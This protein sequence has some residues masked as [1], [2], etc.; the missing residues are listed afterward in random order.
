[1]SSCAERLPV[2]V[3][4]NFQAAYGKNK[5][6]LDFNQVKFESFE[7]LNL[8]FYNGDIWIK[9][10]ITNGDGIGSYMVINNDLICRNYRFYKWNTLTSTLDAAEPLRDLD[11]RDDRTHNFPNPNFKI[12]LKPF[13]KATYVIKLWSDGR[14]IDASPRLMNMDQYTQ[15]INQKTVWSYAFL[16]SM[17][18]L[19]FINFYQWRVL[20]RDIYLYY[21]LYMFSTFL[22][23][24]GL[25]GFW[26]NFGLKHLY[27]DHIIFVA[28]R[29]W[30]FSLLIYTSKFLD[31]K[32][33]APRYFKLLKWLL[34][35]VLGGSTLYQFIFFN[36]SIGSLHMYENSMSFVWLCLIVITLLFSI[37][38]KK[39]ELKYYLIPLSCFLFFTILG[40][41]DGYIKTLPG[42][43]FQYIKTGTL[44]EFIGFTYLIALLIKTKLK[45]SEL[46]RSEFNENKKELMSVSEKLEAL[47]QEKSTET[48]MNKADLVGV[49]KLLENSIVDDTSWEEFKLRFESLNPHFHSNIKALH[50][51]LSKSEMRLL[52]LIKID[53]SQKEIANILN[54]EP[55]SVK[56][57]KSRVRKKLNISSSTVLKDYISKF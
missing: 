11:R 34:I 41:I 45:N 52:T 1:M 47:Q 8:G 39:L 43:P 54:I 49:L 26:Y 40:L 27:I 21:L 48:K 9:L 37:R 46:L 15:F 16:L 13:E 42:E 53:Y 24:L 2:D 32:V 38:T 20:K 14:F 10:D 50:P 5:Q 29:L 35:F 56:K 33:V 19:L 18:L 22:M 55:E 17:I 7:S 12:E 6:G 30:I 36:S 44:I 51:D 25:E 57:A 23:Y 31:T 3:E 4:H 28:I